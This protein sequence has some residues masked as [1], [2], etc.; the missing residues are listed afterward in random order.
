MN[1]TGTRRANGDGSIYETIE[2]HKRKKFLKEE[3]NICKDCT[4]RTACNNREGYIKCEKCENCKTECLK[5]CDRFYC[6]KKSH[7]QISID[8]QQTTVGNANIK[9]EAIEQKKQA[10]AKA[11]TK[12]YIKK[13]GVTLLELIKKVDDEKFKNNKIGKNTVGTNKYKYDKIENSIL[14]EMPIQKITHTMLQDFLNEYKY[15]SNSEI[16][17]LYCKLKQ[18]FDRAVLDK[19]INYPDNPMFRVQKPLSDKSARKVEAF[20]I[21]EQI[22]LMEYLNN[23]TLIS[24]TS[25]CMY[26]ENTF[27]NCVF[28]ALLTGMR[29]GELASLDYTRDINW[30][31]NCFIVHRSLS[32]DEDNQ[33]I[34]GMH[35]KG[36][37]QKEARGKIDERE[38]PFYIFDKDLFLYILNNQIEIAKKIPNNK[39]HLLFCRKDGTYFTHGIT[40]I[41]KRICR[42]AKIKLDLVEGCHI[43]MCRHTAITRMIEAGIDLMVIATIV[44]HSDTSQIEHTYGHVL[45][46]FRRDQLTR[47]QDFYSNNNMLTVQMKNALYKK[48]A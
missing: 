36:G 29:I 25:K 31:K 37:R 7:A 4:D 38:V 43:H 2:K 5:Y 44:G 21:H 45:E 3:C 11:I 17:K 41:F 46:K 1:S 40:N 16:D 35:T 22:A 6:Y 19:V 10:E 28:L 12:T 48:Q 8:G 14:N 47:S 26:D 32:R 42:E 27:K 33:T 34:M 23:S 39:E 9:K 18:G 15:L 20:E 13:N 24:N 30:E